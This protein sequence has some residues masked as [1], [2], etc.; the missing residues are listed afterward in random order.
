MKQPDAVPQAVKDALLRW[1]EQHPAGKT[2]DGRPFPREI[3]S[4]RWDP[5][6]GCYYFHFAGMYC[7]V[8]I[9]GYIHT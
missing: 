5:C 6:N 1:A 8:E 4:I 2:R 3:P 9:D 7:G